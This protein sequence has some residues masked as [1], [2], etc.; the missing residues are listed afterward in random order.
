MRWS[1]NRNDHEK[2]FSAKVLAKIKAERLRDQ[3]RP[4]VVSSATAGGD[5]YL[6]RA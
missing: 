2:A 5:D 3:V 1:R 6:P 4:H